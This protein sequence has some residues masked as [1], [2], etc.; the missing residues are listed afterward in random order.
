M[1]KIIGRQN[2]IAKVMGL[3]FDMDKMVGKDFETGLARLKAI[4]EK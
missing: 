1:L 3:F 4:A 2:L